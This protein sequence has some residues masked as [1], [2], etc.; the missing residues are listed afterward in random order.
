MQ[1][2]KRPHHLRNLLF[3]KNISITIPTPCHENWDAMTPQDTG[4]FCGSCQK[5]VIDF[6]NMSDRQVAEFFKKPKGA[7]CGR[8][9][10]DQLDRD[11]RISKKRIPWMKYYFQVTWPAFVLFL[12][13]CGQKENSMGKS[14]V[15]IS[16]QKKETM[17]YSMV[18]ELSLKTMPEE[19]LLN[20]R[21]IPKVGELSKQEKSN[22]SAPNV[23]MGDT[24]A[25][26]VQAAEETVIIKEEESIVTQECFKR[27]DTVTITG[28]ESTRMGKII[29]GGI[30]VVRVQEIKPEVT[31]INELKKDRNS[32]IAYPNPVIA[33]TPLTIKASFPEDLKQIQLLSN[34]GQIISLQSNSLKTGGSVVNMPA[35]I[36]A[37][38]YFIRIV[39]AKDQAKTIKVIVVK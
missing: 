5:T 36:A 27:M 17:S 28:Y 1:F 9:H 14:L 23:L 38:T 21:P 24:I 8:F 35:N 2:V 18:G 25:L 32:F 26:P 29:A 13:S 19:M 15:E 4:K 39:T 6:S 7:V 12:K 22:V 31:L 3:M 33:G 37:G 16:A 34:S 10:T 20:Q 11:I 30:S